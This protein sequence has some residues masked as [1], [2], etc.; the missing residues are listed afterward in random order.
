MECA[1]RGA[2]PIPCALPVCKRPECE[3]D[4]R[5]IPC[6]C[7]GKEPILRDP[8]RTFCVHARCAREEATW[9]RTRTERG[10]E[11]MGD[12]DEDAAAAEGAEEGDLGDV[13][14]GDALVV[15]VPAARLPRGVDGGGGGG[16]G[17]TAGRYVRGGGREGGREARARAAR[18]EAM[19][20]AR[21][22]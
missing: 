8:L 10:E 14:P 18:R 1:W 16:G 15:R 13:G 2:E 19:L 22:K 9:T 20:I 5:L 6:P 7:T 17:V 12:L 11:R 4:C 21:G 3:G